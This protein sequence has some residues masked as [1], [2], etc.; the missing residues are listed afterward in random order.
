MEWVIIWIICGVIGALIGR[1]KGRGGAGFALGILLGPLGVI[2][3]A[4]MKAD[5][6]AVEF[7]AIQS[8]ES[9]KCPYCAE[10]IKAEAT[11]CRYCGK[12]L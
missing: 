6:S 1:S 11:V 2:I 4:V 12:E 7:S 3:A 5:T 8:G 9:K 10:L